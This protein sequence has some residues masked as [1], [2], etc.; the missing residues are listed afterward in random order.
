MEMLRAL[1]DSIPQIATDTG[2][3]EAALVCAF[4][5]LAAVVLCVMTNCA[6]WQQIPP[7]ALPALRALR[8]FYILT[9]LAGS[10]GPIV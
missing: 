10:I 3:P 8:I 9:A 4:V 7:H 6:A 5:L 2:V 1:H